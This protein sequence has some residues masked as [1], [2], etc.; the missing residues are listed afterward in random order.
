M[1]SWEEI[2]KSDEWYTPPSV[3]C[4]LGCIFDMDVAAARNGSTCVP[5]YAD[6]YAD[7]LQRRWDGFIWMNPPFGGR[8]A[9]VP[10][11]DKFI[12]HGNGIALVPDRTSAPWFQR[13][14]QR[15]DAVLFTSKLK[16]LRPDGSEGKSPSCG[17]ALMAIGQRGTQSLAAARESGFGILC[18]PQ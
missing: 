10:W 18:H 1:S 9:I 17:T 14:F 4:A 13:A 12:E 11:L 6:I 7:S 2:G 5:V 3:F 16:F 8:N 15:M